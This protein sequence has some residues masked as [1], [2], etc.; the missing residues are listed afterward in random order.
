MGS[1]V[2]Q[3]VQRDASLDWLRG[4]L[5]VGVL[6]IH[7]RM[8]SGTTIEMPVGYLVLALNGVIVPVFFG[9]SGLLACHTLN[10]PWATFFRA[11]WQRLVWPYLVWLVIGM[12][13]SVHVIH[14]WSLSKDVLVDAVLRPSRVTTA[15]YLWYAAVFAVI[16]KLVRR[17]P[18]YLVP[19]VL[20]AAMGGGLLTAGEVPAVLIAATSFF[21]GVECARSGW[22]EVAE[23]HLPLRVVA[24]VALALA[25][26]VLLT[27]TAVT[28]EEV[29][30]DGWASLVTLVVVASALLVV[31]AF[32]PPVSPAVQYLGRHSII[33]Y[34]AHWPVMLTVM[35]WRDRASL[36]PGVCFTLMLSTA[37]A[38]CVVACRGSSRYAVVKT[39]FE[40]PRRRR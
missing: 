16:A 33:L 14:E 18:R 27:W 25:L 38:V 12:F 34:V 10:R 3:S 21:I 11:Q 23:R 28:N 26:T 17:L 40:W 30:W 8:L 19:A 24:G 32:Q 37:L 4:V 2:A 5:V 36:T 20:G 39:L 6:L 22:R 1:R 35:V 13:F 29:L 9:V 15:W 31:G 7:A